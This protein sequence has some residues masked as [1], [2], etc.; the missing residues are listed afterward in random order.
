MIIQNN[1]NKGNGSGDDE[2]IE[3]DLD[4]LNADDEADILCVLINIYSNGY[5]FNN[6]RNCFARLFDDRNKELCRFNL[7]ESYST[8][9]MIMCHVEKRKNGC[10]GMITDGVGS[11]GHTAEHCVLIEKVEDK[12]AIPK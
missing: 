8:E 7:T 5:S 11:V 1:I 10:W 12:L 2:V 4:R 9:A 6:I 3:I